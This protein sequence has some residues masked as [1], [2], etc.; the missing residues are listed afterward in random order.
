[1]ALSER[2]DWVKETRWQRLRLEDSSGAE[3]GM[4]EH[5]VWEPER[6]MGM[7][8]WSWWGETDTV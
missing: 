7:E 5:Y 6:K 3:M 4:T 1:M 2:I 8:A